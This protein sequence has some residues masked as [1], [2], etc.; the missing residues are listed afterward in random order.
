MRLAVP[1][2]RARFFV[3]PHYNNAAAFQEGAW[4]M[5]RL[6]MLTTTAVAVIAGTTIVMTDDRFG[7]SIREFLSG[8]E[9]VPFVLTNGRGTLTASINAA[10]TEL[11]YEL[12]YSGLE[13]DATQ[14]HIHIGQSGVNGGISVFLCANTPPITPPPAPAS[15]PPTCPLREGSVEGVLTARDVIGPT[16]QGVVAGD[17]ARLL[18]AIRVGQTYVNVHTTRSPGGEIRSQIDHH[19]HR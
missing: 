10:E 13:A 5:R 9:E 18:H 16:S 1:T 19:G 6:A 17:F 7:R 3:L 11:A 4:T 8:S 12:R 14:A 2:D 15:V